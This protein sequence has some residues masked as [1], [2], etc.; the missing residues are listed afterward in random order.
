MRL[1]VGTTRAILKQALDQLK[2]AVNEIKTK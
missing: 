2:D 1:N